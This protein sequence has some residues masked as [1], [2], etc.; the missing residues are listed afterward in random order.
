M[1]KRI[2][3]CAFMTL[4]IFPLA[5]NDKSLK[6]IEQQLNSTKDSSE[7]FEL[8]VKAGNICFTKADFVAAQKYF[9]RALRIAEKLKDEQKIGTACNN[10]ANTFF[11][12]G[13]FSEAENYSQKAISIFTRLQKHRELG[14]AYNSLANVYYMQQRDTLALLYYQKSLEQRKLTNDSLGLFG[15][16]KNLGAVYYYL[17]DTIKAI[18]YM[19]Q[20]TRYL[21]EKDDSARW[22]SAYMTLGE[23]YVYAGYL[24]KGKQRLD[25]AARFLPAALPYHKLD[26]YHHALYRYYYSTGKYSKALDEY[27]KYEKYKDSVEN[28]EKSKQLHE[29]NIQYETEKK[30]L[31]IAYQQVL[32]KKEQQAKRLYALIFITILLLV[33]S[34]FIVYRIRQKRKT[35]RLQQQQS[36]Q[37]IRE[38]FN[39][40]QKERVRIARDLHDSIGQKLAVMRMLLPKS[41]AQ[42]ELQKIAD[43][44]DETAIEVRNISHNLIPEILNFGLVKAIEG[45]ADRI[46]STE[47]VKVN[48]TVDESKKKI[49]LSKQT[50]LSLYRIVQEI[51]SNILRHSQTDCISMELKTFDNFVQLNIKDNGV[52]F[53]SEKIDDSQGLGWKNIFARI[54]L[55]NGEIKIQSEKNKGT[56]FLI[57]IPIT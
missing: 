56:H 37:I 17:G 18:E 25:V 5:A 11:E 31:L 39:A 47:S 30:E 23:L 57:N 4:T 32:I 35:E 8:S 44:L 22:F 6:E 34:L 45:M 50:E 46:N 29:L 24:E 16:L 3:F 42:P 38:I 15:T 14:N 21:T 27:I 2:V 20:S 28:I 52:G 10:I 7:L 13:K 49:S 51:L 33:F 43:F 12:T 41:D 54:K 40:E 9:F 53:E 48:F 55:I 36:E 19:E 1:R 26:D